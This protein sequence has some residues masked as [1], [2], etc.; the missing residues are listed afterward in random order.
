MKITWSLL[1]GALLAMAAVP[2]VAQDTKSDE[3]AKSGETGAGRKIRQ[4]ASN[5]RIERGQRVSRPRA[6]R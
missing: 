5:R 1:V 4:T 2:L 3:V 6:T